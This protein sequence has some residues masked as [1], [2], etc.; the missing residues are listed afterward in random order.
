RTRPEAVI[1]LIQ[2][3]SYS[4]PSGHAMVSASF[5][6]FVAYLAWRL[7]RGW[8]RGVLVVGLALLVVAIG[9]S[10]IY[11]QAHYLSDV[12]A[13]YVAGFVWTDA[14]ILGSQVLSTERR[15]TT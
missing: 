4:F 8:W 6:F 12:I 10:R 14:V 9:V 13:G 11:L 5:Y 3:Q 7:V 1:S 15:R 2:A